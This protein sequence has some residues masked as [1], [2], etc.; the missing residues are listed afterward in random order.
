MHS[1]QDFFQIALGHP[2][3]PYQ[4][5][6]ANEPWP[7]FVEVPTGLGKTAAI[8]MAWLYKRWR[9][10]P[11]TPTRLVYT[12]PMRALVEQTY[13][14]TCSWRDKLQDVFTKS[15]IALPTVHLLMGGD[16]DESWEESPEHPAILIGT[17]DQL[18]SRALNR[19]YAMSRYR[20][21]MHFGLLHNDALWIFD[22]IQ[23]MGVSVETS[24]QLQAL[25]EKLGC[26]G[27][28]HSIWMSA[29]LDLQRLETVDYRESSA[30]KVSLALS[31]TEQAQDTIQRRIRAN[32]QLQRVPDLVLHKDEKPEKQPKGTKA[33][34][35]PN[36]AK[37]QEQ[38]Y[39]QKLA[40]L[41]LQHH[42]ENSLTLVIL[43]SVER[44]RNVFQALLEAGRATENTGLIH[45][46]FRRPERDQQEKI[47]FQSGDRIVVATQVVEAGI[48]VSAKTMFTELAPFSSLIQ[49]WGRCNRY[50]EYEQARI[51]WIDIPL[52]DA[53]ADPQTLA[54]PYEM[55]DLKQAQELL[56][57]LYDDA[58]PAALSKV[59]YEPLPKLRP[60]LR[61]RDLIELFDTT[62]DLTGSDIDISRYIRDQQDTDVHFYWRNLSEERPSNDTKTPHRDE[63][64]AVSVHQAREFIKLVKK[65]EQ[66]VWAWNHLNQ[67][68]QSVESIYPGQTILIPAHLG[69]YDSLL[70]WTGQLY[71]SK[72]AAV[73]EL[74]PDA[75]AKN[76]PH[77]GMEDEP[78]T[79]IH[80]QI[81]LLQHLVDVTEATRKVIQN[82]PLSPEHRDALVEAAQWHDVGKAHDVFQNMLRSN[83]SLDQKE[84]ASATLWA[85]SDGQ[86]GKSNRRYF[87]HELASALAWLEHTPDDH[88]L[89]N[90][91]AYLIVSHHGKVRLSIRAVPGEKGPSN[92]PDQLFARGVWHGD[93]LPE[94]Q[95]PNGT[96]VGPF[97]L[98]L[99][100]MQLGPG[101][102]LER[103]LQL[104][105]NPQL[106]PFRLGY[107]ETLLRVADWRASAEESSA[108]YQP[109]LVV[110]EVSTMASHP[111]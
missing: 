26:F 46:R 62:T 20:W 32:K 60:V 9:R 92:H 34:K 27:T 41:V 23:L 68:W 36:D 31:E 75:L 25:R 89:K 48:D 95:L 51:F 30:N 88:A 74:S 90:L 91:I 19:G 59:C 71:K 3:Y 72:D 67:R 28:S 39:A 69:G 43:N 35:Q 79:Y 24:A 49:R 8:I 80:R 14:N 108:N 87:R 70:G 102:W 64:C 77:E 4:E 85:K 101:S 2:P 93:K 11:H 5:R 111:S 44:T 78:A 82:L 94:V 56:Q 58:S 13:Q 81:S 105:D 83:L 55:D 66:S 84:A 63:L 21:P 53:D 40:H 33:K 29:T 86:K 17:Q 109:A 76:R 97:T 100:V 52:D 18:L 38:T 99:S 65:Q 47:L 37:Q 73:P 107:L 57:T 110:S 103:M 7:T 45:S 6:L 12:L 42:Q 1:Y 54:L 10:D 22:E 106:G 98:D 50:G 16:T 96:Q 61:R 15:G 104:R